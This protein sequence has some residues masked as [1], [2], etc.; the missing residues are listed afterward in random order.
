M[1]MY[2]FIL[3]AVAASQQPNA[4]HIIPT[5]LH[6]NK[7]TYFCVNVTCIVILIFYMI[8]SEIRLKHFHTDI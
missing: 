8:C 3:C 5:N 1:I 7:G 4:G 6:T 2:Q